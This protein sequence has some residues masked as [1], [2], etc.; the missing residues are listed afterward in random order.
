VTDTKTGNGKAIGTFLQRFPVS[1]PEN[2]G[3]IIYQNNSR[4]KILCASESRFNPHILSDIHSTTGTFMSSYK[5]I[6]T[7]LM[8][9]DLKKT[10]FQ[11]G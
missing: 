4:R 1:V 5:H 7:S 11:K 6:H 8:I 9:C 2:V 3:K 10:L